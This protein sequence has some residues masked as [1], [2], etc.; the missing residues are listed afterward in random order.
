[1]RFEAHSAEDL[2]AI[3]GRVQPLVEAEIRRQTMFIE[4]G[5]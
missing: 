5:L 4:K 3:Q 2:A 1:M